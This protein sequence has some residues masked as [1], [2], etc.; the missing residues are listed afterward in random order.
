M[1]KNSQKRNLLILVGILVVIAV[2][3]IIFSIQDLKNSNENQGN[4]ELTEEELR[5]IGKMVITEEELK[6]IDLYEDLDIVVEN[7]YDFVK[8]Y[9]GDLETSDY[10]NYIK[11]LNSNFATLYSDI[12]EAN[13]SK[14]Y[15][16]D[17][18]EELLKKY[19]IS[20]YSDFQELLKYIE[21]YQTPGLTYK[22]VSLKKDTVK[23]QG[24]YVQTT[25]NITYSNNVTQTI[26]I[27]ALKDT[28]KDLPKFIL[29]F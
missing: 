17:N 6:N 2:F 16:E 14:K 19:G 25:V 13:D 29:S 28:S 5:K 12:K 15:F 7:L 27:S 10:T 21:I 22:T 24:D 11:N 1:E 4:S 20:E 26:N 9:R 18:N 3:V 8:V 23:D